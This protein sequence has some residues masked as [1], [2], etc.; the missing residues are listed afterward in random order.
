MI[1]DGW[2]LWFMMIMIMTR[3]NMTAIVSETVMM[4]TFSLFRCCGCS[5]SR[6]VN[7]LRTLL[8]H[9]YIAADAVWK[10]RTTLHSLNYWI[11]GVFLVLEAQSGRCC[12]V[13][14]LNFQLGF[15]FWSQE[16]PNT[17]QSH[18]LH[19]LRKHLARASSCCSP[20]SAGSRF[21]K[22]PKRGSRLS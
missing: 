14:T 19:S 15:G 2:W 13:W 3:I 6:P 9:Y 8:L 18:A 7:L 12:W 4:K 11:Y 5:L 20:R 16:C 1:F 22:P 17:S 10:S 21:P